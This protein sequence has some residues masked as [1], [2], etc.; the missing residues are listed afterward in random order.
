M[1]KKNEKQDKSTENKHSQQESKMKKEFDKKEIEKDSKNL[2]VV[3]EEKKEIKEEV[4]EVK[5]SNSQ[6]KEVAITLNTSS[7]GVVEYLTK[8]I[9]GKLCS[10]VI[11]SDKMVNV[12]LCLENFDNIILYKKAGFFGQKYLSLINDGTYPNTEVIQGHGQNWYL[13]DKIK[14]YVDGNY[15]AIVKVILRYY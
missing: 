11:D 13:N 12:K 4:E 7:S 5:Y 9:N 14:I 1:D 2:K 8:K 6:I 10:V 3:T 15:N